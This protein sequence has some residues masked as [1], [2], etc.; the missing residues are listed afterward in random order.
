MRVLLISMKNI[1]ILIPF[2]LGFTACTPAEQSPDAENWVTVNNNELGIR[3]S[4]PKEW[5][6]W[7]MAQQPTHEA[8]D[9]T[10]EMSFTA[11]QA[12]LRSQDI[13]SKDVRFIFRRYDS[14]VY[15]YEE[16]CDT[17]KSIDLCDVTKQKDLLEEKNQFEA[18]ATQEIGG[19]PATIG[20]RYDA[21]SAFVMREVRLYTPSYRVDVIAMFD[22]GDFLLE[23]RQDPDMSLRS[24]AQNVLGEELQDPIVQLQNKNTYSYKELSDFYADVD[25]FIESISVTSVSTAEIFTN[26]TYGFS[27]TPF[28]KWEGYQVKIRNPSDS[29]ISGV[30]MFDIGFPTTD[31]DFG[32]D[33]APFITI[34]VYTKAQ[35]ERIQNE[36]GPKPGFLDQNSKYVFTYSPAQ[37]L[38]KELLDR[39]VAFDEQV[40]QERFELQ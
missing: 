37:D 11:L 8:S 14:D 15:R 13:Q 30:A 23:R 16:V 27:F 21:P 26:T 29:A 25:R 5:G 4:Q 18:S 36:E 38:P 31:K 34:V 1:L 6:E 20:D 35:W 17:E 9:T 28:D 32:S 33:F 19:V 22:I 10:V 7:Q 39:A 40:I 2:V 12:S 3:F 24:V